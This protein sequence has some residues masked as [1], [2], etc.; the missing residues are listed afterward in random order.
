MEYTSHTLFIS[1][2]QRPC[3]D[4]C[5]ANYRTSVR[6]MW[7]WWWWWWCVTGLCCKVCT[8]VS[9]FVRAMS[10][11]FRIHTVQPCNDY[12]HTQ[13]CVSLPHKLNTYSTTKSAHFFT[14][15]RDITEVMAGQRQCRILLPK[16]MDLLTVSLDAEVSPF[17]F[18]VS[19]V[20]RHYVCV[21]RRWRFKIICQIYQIKCH[22]KCILMQL[23][24]VVFHMAMWLVYFLTG[25][26]SV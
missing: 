7:W 19:R 2:P 5:I 26:N 18:K 1:A 3:K 9:C 15:V 10:G 20:G 8:V 4:V 16:L 24:K 22:G 17:D 12:T 13:W 21:N 11:W 6:M 23:G 25:R 14:A